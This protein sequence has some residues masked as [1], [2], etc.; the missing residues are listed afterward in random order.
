VDDLTITAE[1]R[2]IVDGIKCDLNKVFK[3]KD[4]GEIHWLLNLKIEHN[5]NAKTIVISQAAYIDHIINRVNLQ[6]AK[7][8]VTPLDP[9]LKLSKDQCH[10]TK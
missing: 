1:S 2:T 8:C 5:W 7:S 3:M 10:E 4:L 9:N 6:D